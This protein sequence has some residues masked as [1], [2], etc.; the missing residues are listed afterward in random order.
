MIRMK[1]HAQKFNVEIINDHI[2]SVDLSD[3]PFKLSGSNEY[4][5]DSLIISTG[6]SDLMRLRLRPS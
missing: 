6:A 3:K 2:T 4:T 1:E 5:C